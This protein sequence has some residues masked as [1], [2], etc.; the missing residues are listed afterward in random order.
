MNTDEQQYLEA[1]LKSLE[2]ACALIRRRLNDENQTS[3]FSFFE[4]V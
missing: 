2:L 1:R 4:A 3:L